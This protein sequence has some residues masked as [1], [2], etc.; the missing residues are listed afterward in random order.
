M[1]VRHR[2]GQIVVILRDDAVDVLAKCVAQ[3]IPR[4]LLASLGEVVHHAASSEFVEVDLGGEVEPPGAPFDSP[5][6]SYS[7]ADCL[8]WRADWVGQHRERV[9]VGGTA[10]LGAH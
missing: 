8:R 5:N 10:S 7:A 2:L 3:G 4:R 9:E 6:L 1:P